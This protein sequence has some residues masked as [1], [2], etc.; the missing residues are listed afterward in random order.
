MARKA[1]TIVAIGWLKLGN[2]ILAISLQLAHIF[3]QVRMG[4]RTVIG[5]LL[6]WR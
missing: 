5:C 4:L 1:T 3:T 2:A 6:R